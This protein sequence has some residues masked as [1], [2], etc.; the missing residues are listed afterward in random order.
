MKKSYQTV[1]EKIVKKQQN[2]TFSNLSDLENLP[3]ERFNKIQLLAVHQYP[4][5]EASCLNRDKK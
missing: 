5:W 1:F 3:L 2:F 4:L